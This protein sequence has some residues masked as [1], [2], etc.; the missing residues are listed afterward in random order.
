VDAGFG[1]VNGMLNGD[2]GSQLLVDMT[3]GAATGGKIGLTN[4]VNLLEAAIVNVGIESYRQLGNDAVTGC[5]QPAGGRAMLVVGGGSLV[6]DLVEEG[7]TTA[8]AELAAERSHIVIS[9]EEV[10][11]LEEG[12]STLERFVS[13]KL[14]CFIPCHTHIFRAKLGS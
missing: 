8:R 9:A 4:G 12:F 1:I 6:G 13:L 11:N 3:A 5:I 7:T 2:R 10:S 14:L